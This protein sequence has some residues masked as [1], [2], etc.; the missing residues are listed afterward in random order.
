MKGPAKKS[1]QMSKVLSLGVTFLL[2]VV[3]V[4]DA[5]TQQELCEEPIMVTT[6]PDTI[7]V[8]DIGVLANEARWDADVVCINITNRGT[9][10][11][12]TEILYSGAGQMQ[13]N[14]S[15]YLDV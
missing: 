2:L 15:F 9:Y 5:S 6:G 3:S 13:M 14:E 12:E 7:D 1:F 8:G 4:P 11:I 10:L